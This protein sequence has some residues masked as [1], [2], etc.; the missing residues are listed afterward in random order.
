MVLGGVKSS[1][2]H[3]TRAKGKKELVPIIVQDYKQFYDAATKVVEKT[4]LRC[5][6]KKKYNVRVKMITHG[7][8]L[9]H[10]L[11]YPK[12]MRLSHRDIL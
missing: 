9:Y 6:Q 8:I 12:H 2:R 4:T 7:N 5:I 10:L 1:V 11:V 3:L